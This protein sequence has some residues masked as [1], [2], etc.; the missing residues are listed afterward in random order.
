MNDRSSHDEGKTYHSDHP[1]KGLEPAPALRPDEPT[2]TRLE[3]EANESRAQVTPR[4]PA[5]TAADAELPIEERRERGMRDNTRH[6][7]SIGQ[8]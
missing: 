1:T 6:V 5:L 3:E 4:E 7:D 2:F 8:R